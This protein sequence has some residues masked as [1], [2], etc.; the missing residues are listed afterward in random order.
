[1]SKLEKETTEIAQDRDPGNFSGRK[2]SELRKV[3]ISSWIGN[4]IEF[5]DFLVYGLAAALVFNTIFFPNISALA[6][7]LAAFATFGVGFIARPLGGAFFGHYGDTLGRKKAL[8]ITLLGMGAATMLVGILP[9]YQQVGI[10]AP[11]L[12]VLLRFMQGFVVG[13]EWG[14]AMLYVVESASP[15]RRGLAGALPQTGGF[16]GQLLATGMFALVTMLN[17]EQLLSWGWRIPFLFSGVLVA[18]GL[19]MRIH[20]EETP[21]FEKLKKKE[22]IEKSGLQVVQKSPVFRVVKKGWKKL[23]TIMVLR[24]A[25]SVPFFLATVFAVS[26]ATEQLGVSNGMML[27]VVMLTC[28]I[29]F[30]AH[31]LFGYISDKIGRRPVYIFGALFAAAF[32]FPFFYL[33]ESGSFALLMLAYFLFI[34]VGHNSINA[35]QPAFFTEMFG[36]SVR[37]S[38]AS[39]GAQL[40]AIVAGG[41]TPFIAKWLTAV[42]GDQWYYL[43]FYVM[44]VSLLSASAAFLTSETINKNI[45]GSKIHR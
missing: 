31:A 28:V 26:Y 32:V 27:S 13:G 22:K 43:A 42:D 4:T 15:S 3:I 17:R 37:Y 44:I 11:I 20:L 24:F 34:N 45:Y 18:V 41:F 30:P 25:E 12:L 16:S 35:V 33:V 2:P 9:T 19:Y 1:M 36:P 8:V 14:G 6:G 40:G 21:V 10:M 23:L 38:G 7:T 5:Y 39:I 29:A